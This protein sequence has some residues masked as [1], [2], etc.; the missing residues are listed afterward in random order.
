MMAATGRN[1]RSHMR[2]TQ[3]LE[4]VKL[5]QDEVERGCGDSQTEVLSC[6]I[7]SEEDEAERNKEHGNENCG[8]KVNAE[9]KL[10]SKEAQVKEEFGFNLDNVEV[11][12]K[13]CCGSESPEDF[14]ETY[15]SYRK[16]LSSPAAASS[17][18]LPVAANLK[19]L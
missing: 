6:Q 16:P 12:Q 7:V 13:I 14:D 3:S 8:E 5:G 17:P 11:P 15:F 1:E 2:G 4:D 19:K 18:F 10:S 9:E